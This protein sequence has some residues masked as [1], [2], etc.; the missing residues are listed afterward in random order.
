MGWIHIMATIIK[1]MTRIFKSEITNFLDKIEDTSKLLEVSIR[2]SEKRVEQMKEALAKQIALGKHFAAKEVELQN[3]IQAITA[4]AE[5]SLKNKEESVT[6]EALQDK[7]KEQKKLEELKKSIQLHEENTVKYR[8]K[9]KQSMAEIDDLK[10]KK[11][12]LVI[13]HQMVKNE[14]ELSKKFGNSN[15]KQLLEK[16]QKEIWETE[17]YISIENQPTIEEKFENIE[18][19]DEVEK[20]LQLMKSNL[21][22][23]KQN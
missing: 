1:R 6:R 7:I 10:V 3:R 5:K 9:L 17:A 22:E 2:D 12:T 16:I 13:K 23:S 11:D 19:I 21:Q 8:T 14:L 20:E 18:Y 15:T 4:H